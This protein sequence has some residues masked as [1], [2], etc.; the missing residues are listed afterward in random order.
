MICDYYV[1]K[2]LRGSV[3]GKYL[4]CLSLNSLRGSVGKKVSGIHSLSADQQDQ[5]LRT[6]S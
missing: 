5:G 3:D 4:I 6:I 1:F 2:F